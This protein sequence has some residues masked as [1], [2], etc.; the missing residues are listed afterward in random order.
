MDR[1]KLYMHRDEILRGK[2]NDVADKYE[3]YRFGYPA[4]LYNRIFEYM[5]GG[6]RA[7]EIGI[8]TGKAT[9]P[10]IDNG[11]SIIAIEP[12]KNMMNIAQKKYDA[13]GIIFIN[14]T[15]EE[16]NLSDKFD[17]IYAA[18]SFQWISGCDRLL[19]VNELLKN[20]GAFARFKTINVID[21]NKTLHNAALIESYMEFLPEY[22]PSDLY[23]KHMKNDEYIAAGFDDF[24]REE[25]YIDHIFKIEDYIKLVNTYTEYILLRSELRSSF[26]SSVFNKL[27]S[28]DIVV[29]QKC[30]L[31]LARKISG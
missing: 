3:Q 31:H 22:L 10:F 25:Y 26:E 27:S 19:K 13:E 4:E 6:D 24:V 1:G 18:S 28:D 5:E 17:L 23:G 30:T 14:K 20:R 11:Y 8:G 29:T 2:F 21:E 12:V 16:T 15:F 9:G 7:L